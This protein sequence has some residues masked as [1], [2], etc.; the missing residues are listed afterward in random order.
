VANNAVTRH[1]SRD[2][3]IEG[4]DNPQH[5]TANA[6]GLVTFEDADAS[7]QPTQLCQVVAEEGSDLARSGKEHS[8]LNIQR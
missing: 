1:P 4:L 6:E 3:P 5:R 7:L 8:T 2:P